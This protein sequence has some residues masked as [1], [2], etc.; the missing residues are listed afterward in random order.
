MVLDSITRLGFGADKPKK[1]EHK[2]KCQVNLRSTR[3]LGRPQ[4]SSNPQH[5]SQARRLRPGLS[6]LF[7][8][9]YQCTQAAKTVSVIRVAVHTNS[10]DL[11]LEVL[12]MLHANQSGRR[13]RRLRPNTKMR[14][15]MPIQSQNFT[16]IGLERCPSD[17]AM[18][19]SRMP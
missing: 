11:T 14:S 18:D 4:S 15:R 2:G 7:P 3:L 19:V 5:P 9:R 8:Q 1:I 13:R 6:R 10:G 12:P 16:G 17:E